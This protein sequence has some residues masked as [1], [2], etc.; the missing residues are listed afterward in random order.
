MDQES[1]CINNSTIFHMHKRLTYCEAPGACRANIKSCATYKMEKG[2]CWS[3]A[4]QWETPRPHRS[5][6]DAKLSKCSLP[7][8]RLSFSKR[9]ALAVNEWTHSNSQQSFT[10][11]KIQ[12]PRPTIKLDASV[13]S[14]RISL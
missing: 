11:E 7:F 14:T 4:G 5:R 8:F 2:G 1:N 10:R 12:N 13:P 9:D 6:P 3:T